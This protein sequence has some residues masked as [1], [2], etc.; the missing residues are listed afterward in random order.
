MILLLG[1]T[2]FIIGINVQAI[3]KLI[4]NWRVLLYRWKNAS[5]IRII[6]FLIVYSFWIQIGFAQS[7]VRIHNF[8]I[9]GYFWGERAPLL[10]LF[11]LILKLIQSKMFLIFLVYVITVF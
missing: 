3:V 9:L 1:K 7:W 4:L 5:A 2:V 11:I 10:N 6:N 8:S